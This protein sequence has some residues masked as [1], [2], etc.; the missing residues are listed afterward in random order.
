MTAMANRS[1]P[2]SR[3]WWSRPRR[4]GRRC[5]STKRYRDC[6]SNPAVTRF[7]SL[8]RI[9]RVIWSAASTPT[10]MFPTSRRRPIS[11]SGVVL[12]LRPAR[13]DGPFRDL[14]P[15]EPTARREFAST[16][17]VTAFARVYQAERDE[18]L[19]VT[20]R[21]RIIDASNRT[22]QESSD[23]IFERGNSASHSADY[24]FELPLASLAAGQYLLTIEATRKEKRDDS[25]RR[26]VFGSV[27]RSYLRN[28]NGLGE[29]IAVTRASDSERVGEFRLRQGYGGHRRSFSGGVPRGKA[30]RIRSERKAERQ[31]HDP[32]VT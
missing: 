27:T 20:V 24:Q 5:F 13:P 28:P 21:R 7:A 26:R 8:R 4:L 16:S 2:R 3:P 25:P 1:R 6:G 15:L 19:P 18:S 9:H 14:F 30:P 10:P 11:L 17:H 32:R 31:L 29:H 23:K 12:G 22:V